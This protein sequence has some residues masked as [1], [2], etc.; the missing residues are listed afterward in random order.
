MTT[1]R[2]PLGLRALPQWVFWALL[3]GCCLACP[4]AY[5]LLDKPVFE[6]QL[7]RG[8]V[9]FSNLW[10]DA[11]RLLGKAWL[12]VWLLLAWVATTSRWRR[13]YAPL[14]ALLI[15]ALPLNATKLLV[16][17]PRPR[18]KIAQ[19]QSQAEAATATAEL[20][21][22]SFPS[23]DTAAAIAVAAAL[24]AAAAWPWAVAAL[25]AATG[26]GVMRVVDLAHH[27]SDVCAGAALGLLV[28]LAAIRLA[29]RWPPPA[30]GT[31]SR[32]VSILGV[33]LIP[34]VTI[35]THGTGMFVLL[36]KTYV[37][38]M[39]AVCIIVNVRRS[40]GHLD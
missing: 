34:I 12:L 17:R 36:L 14:L 1:A 16:G 18:Q 26:V 6:W 33:V 35:V 19:M 7:R 39:L 15:L 24:G 28:A 20:R 38:L 4:L 10:I 13:V 29:P 25:L 21:G 30:V 40:R 9:P 8:F 11:F 23:G 32:P 31:W 27:P 5:L 22:L 2:R 37:P 3:A